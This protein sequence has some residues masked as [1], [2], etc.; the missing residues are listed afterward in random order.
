MSVATAQSHTVKIPLGTDTIELQTNYIAKLTESSVVVSMGE[1]K[2]LVTVAHVPSTDKK[3]FFP[4]SVHYVEKHYAGSKIPGGFTRRE[5]RPSDREV[6]ISRL[7]DR[8]IRPLFPKDFYDEVQVVCTLLSLNPKHQPD[9]LSIIGTSAALNLSSLPFYDILTAIRV[10]EVD[11][12][13]T[14]NH[15]SE[16]SSS[17]DLV[18]AGLND[19]ILMVEAECD[20]TPEEKM[21]EAFVYGQNMMKLTLEALTPWIAEHKKEKITVQTSDTT[22]LVTEMQNKYSDDLKKAIHISGKQERDESISAIKSTIIS[23]MSE[24]HEQAD[25]EDAMQQFVRAQMRSMIINDNRR[26]DGRDP[27]T[28]RP[29]TIDT[30]FFSPGFGPHGGVVFTR[31]ETQ[32]IVTSTLGN[33]RDAQLLDHAIGESKGRFMLHYNFPPF[34]VGE[35]GMLATKRREIGHGALARKALNAVLP[36]EDKFPYVIRVVSEITES[37]GSSSMATVCG[38]S[39]S[40]MMAGVPLKKPIAGVALGLLKE[41]AWKTFLVTWTSKLPDPIQV[42]LRCRWI[43]KSKVSQPQHWIKHSSKP[44]KEESIS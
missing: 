11:G 7:I 15:N 26:V 31:G 12:Q 44:I 25:I 36:S 9:V 1:T 32:A 5:G 41:A 33:D 28:V 38:G 35:A 43:S 19:S 8:S 27:Q 22:H 16:E 18:I 20:E 29:I 40:L 42:S 14:C 34:C 6:L 4:L 39:L 10:S 2:I 17:L 3:E 21:S 24:A 23:D 37:N 30:N 13:F